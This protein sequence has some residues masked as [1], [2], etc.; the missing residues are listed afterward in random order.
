MSLK[1]ILETKGLKNKSLNLYCNN[2]QA[3]TAEYE[4]LKIDTVEILDLKVTDAEVTGEL[5]ANNVD[6]TG[7]LK[8]DEIKYAGPS[9]VCSYTQPVV[10][11]NVTTKTA[12]M[13]SSMVQINGGT[14]LDL[15]MDYT[16]GSQYTF[17]I[18]GTW[19]TTN[20]T[21]LLATIDLGFYGLGTPN[22]ISSTGIQFSS[23]PDNGS[24]EIEFN[25]SVV[26]N[27][28]TN[29]TWQ[30]VN[31]NKTSSSASSGVLSLGG[32][33]IGTQ[34]LVSETEPVITL[35]PANTNSTIRC[36]VLQA[37]KLYSP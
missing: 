24:F 4:D 37:S 7:E 15:L 25:I 33:V 14:N 3:V 35:T 36:Y 9:S 10:L 20:P 8:V 29:V 6:I 2:I 30:G 21:G 17:K 23:I 18:M 11:T 19:S 32:F 28:G 13:L 34:S 16:V 31:F 5:K 26:A 12:L 27:D 22:T 1:P